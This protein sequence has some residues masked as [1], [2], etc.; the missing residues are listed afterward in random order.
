MSSKDYVEAPGRI[1]S[2]RSNDDDARLYRYAYE[3]F[4]TNKFIYCWFYEKKISSGPGF[5][6]GS[7]ALCADQPLIRLYGKLSW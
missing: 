3:K 5:E 7:T 2:C 4:H 1:S 6:L